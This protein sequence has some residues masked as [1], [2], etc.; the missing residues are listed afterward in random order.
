MATVTAVTDAQITAAQGGDSDAMWSIV[1]AYEPMIRSVIRSAAP[2]AQGTDIEDLLQEGRIVLIQHIRQY[3]TT[4]SSASLT[5]YA[6][7][8]LHRAIAEEWIRMSNAFKVDPTKVIRVRHALWEAEG[9]VERAW[10]IVSTKGDLTHRMSRE[11]FVSVC[12]ALMDVDSV[13]GP[14]H[15][16]QWS[17]EGTRGGAPVL[18]RPSPTPPRTSP[19][20]RSVSRSHTTSSVRSRSAR[21]TPSARSTGSA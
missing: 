13:E 1:S 18:P 11:A 8:S 10:E 15:T 17:G 12:E 2:A 4:A 16:G 6:Y 3:D 14:A 21:R 5:S 9:N 19:T 7:R 20:R